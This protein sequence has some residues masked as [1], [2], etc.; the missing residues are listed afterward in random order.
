MT[1]RFFALRFFA[2]LYVLSG[3]LLVLAPILLL[4]FWTNVETPEVR[5]LLNTPV[6]L[7]TAIS[8]VVACAIV[9]ISWPSG[10]SCRCLC[11]SKRTRART[12]SYFLLL[13][14]K[15]NHAKSRKKIAGIHS[16][17]RKQPTIASNARTAMQPHIV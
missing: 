15:Q 14:A 13:I 4:I 5:R 17:V 12:H 8:I 11:R 7:L 1:K 3:A 9:G 6:A 2:G 10:N 16:P